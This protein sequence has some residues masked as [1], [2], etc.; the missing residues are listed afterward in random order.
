MIQVILQNPGCGARVLMS[1]AFLPWDVHLDQQLLD[2]IGAAGFV[3]ENDFP[4]IELSQVTCQF[5]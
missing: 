5:L 1:F 4:I 2:G 3:P